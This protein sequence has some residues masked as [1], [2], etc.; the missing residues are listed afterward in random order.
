MQN[1]DA[2]VI[3]SGMG[4]LAFAA[5]M[6]KTGG[7]RVLV[8]E[9]HFR[10]GGFTHA[11]TR[12]ALT[13]KGSWEWDVGLHY[14]GGMNK[15]AM[16]RTLMD[17]ITGGGIEWNEMPNEYDQFHYPGMSFT[18]PASAKEYE[19]KLGA[20]FPQ[21]RKAIRRYFRDVRKATGWMTRHMMA[22]SS[23]AP[24]AAVVRMVNRR[25]EKF[26]LQTTGQYLNAHFRD[27]QLRA[28]LASQWGDYGLP[29]AES[30]FAIHALIVTHYFGGAYY[31]DGGAGR[32]ADG[33]ARIIR[34]AG[35]DV[36][37][38]HEVS[39]IVIEGGRAVGVEVRRNVGKGG[40]TVEF[41]APAIVSDAG[42]ANTFLKLLPGVEVPFKAKL[43]EMTRHGNTM[44]S[45]YLGFK[46]DPRELGFQG[47]NHWLFDGIDHDRIA[48]HADDIVEGRPHFCYLSFP[49]LKNPRAVRHTGEILSA[50][51]Y[52]S[53]ARFRDQPWRRR[54]E[55]YDAMKSKIAEGLIDFVERR[56]PGFQEMVEFVEV[57]TP[58]SVEHFTAHAQGTIYGIPATP[59]RCRQP[60]L[61][62]KTCVPGLYLTGADAA[63]AGIM[64]ALMGGVGAASHVLGAAG[65]LK[66]MIAA[67][68]SPVTEARRAALKNA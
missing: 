59:E 19:A 67:N 24:I 60:W 20:R 11:F 14:V 23:P 40:D 54:A 8:L 12:P 37:V 68:R 1:Y 65:F 15:G 6:A 45:V 58:L 66:I 64:G 25:T 46:R 32:I 30:A 3:G 56:F 34:A 22:N 35:G 38:N 63:S 61:A 5:I 9:R 57:S 53:V 4:G 50:L 44:A 21:E 29:P 55:E 43:A 18:V 31:P 52:S 47:E 13:S 33:A 26:A 36:L 28:V 27:P 7:R 42:A 10:A 16:G 41:R 49:S 17:F 51:S 48:A 62:P 2:I 39:R